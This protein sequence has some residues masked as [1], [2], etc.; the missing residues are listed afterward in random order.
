MA[1]ND[2]SGWERQLAQRRAISLVCGEGDGNVDLT[3]ND[4]YWK[5]GGSVFSV[6]MVR[7]PFLFDEIAEGSSCCLL[8]LLLYD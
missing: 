4:D 8:E 5:D 1:G 2:G 7:G 6:I 3:I